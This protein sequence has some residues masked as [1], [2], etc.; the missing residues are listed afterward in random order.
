M[1]Y[2]GKPV[3]PFGHGLRYT[4]FATSWKTKRSG[5]YSSESLVGK[6]GNDP[7]NAVF[8]DL[9]ITAK[10]QGGKASLASDYVALLFLNSG[11]AGPSPRPNKKLVSYARTDKRVPVGQSEDVQLRISIGDLARSDDNGDKYLYPGDYTIALD[12]TGVIRRRLS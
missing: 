12:T 5:A 8:A 3:L 10:N 2:T 7:D 6:A 9:A 11:N 4:D 1:W